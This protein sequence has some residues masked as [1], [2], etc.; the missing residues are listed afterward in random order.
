MLQSYRASGE[1]GARLG[2]VWNGAHAF[3][4]TP[5]EVECCC[6]GHSVQPQRRRQVYRKATYFSLTG[7]AA[8]AL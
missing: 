8:T 1:G 4:V 3:Q 5:I 6:D 2:V 7:S